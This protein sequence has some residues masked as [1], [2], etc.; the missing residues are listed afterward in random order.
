MRISAR[1]VIRALRDAWG[2]L[3]GERVVERTDTCFGVATVR[4]LTWEGERMRVLE[5]DG[6]YQSATYLDDRY[7]ELPFPY[8]RLFGR[9]FDLDPAPRDILMLGGG[10][11]AFPKYAIAM[12]DTV[13]VD[14]VEID[15]V[16]L[17]LAHRHFFLDRLEEDYGAISSGRLNIYNEDGRAF[18]ERSYQEGAY[19]DA[20]LIDCFCAADVETSLTGPVAFSY[21]HG[22]LRPRGVLVLNVISALEGADAGPIRQAISALSQS[23]GHAVVLSE[24][25]L[26][27]DAADNRCV[28]ASDEKICL[29]GQ[30]SL[31]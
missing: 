31:F 15:P 8:L 19:Y 7:I 26:E 10:A 6:T 12:S 23:F 4:D 21:A 25:K 3:F 29:E 14:V 24:G 20:I 27:A 28:V 9:V 5:V 17:A 22:C 30:I 2:R 18:L 16:V 1:G 13:R 11:L